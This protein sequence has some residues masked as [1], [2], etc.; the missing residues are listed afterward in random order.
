MGKWNTVDGKWHGVAYLN[1]RKINL[2][3]CAMLRLC[4]E[5]NG[6]KLQRNS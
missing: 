5:K 4:T 6:C 1:A 3:L 2:L